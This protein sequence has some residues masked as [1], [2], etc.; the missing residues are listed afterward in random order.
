[1]PQAV[2]IY[3]NRLGD[4]LFVLSRAANRSAGCKDVPWNHEE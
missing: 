3:L 1:V 4:L 2:L